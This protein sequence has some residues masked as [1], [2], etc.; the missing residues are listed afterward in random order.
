[1]KTWQDPRTRVT[2][3][4]PRSTVGIVNS[5]GALFFL[6]P[7]AMRTGVTD[8]EPTEQRRVSKKGETTRCCYSEAG[9]RWR[10]GVC[11][12]FMPSFLNKWVISA[13]FV[14]MNFD[15]IDCCFFMR[16]LE[17]YSKWLAKKWRAWARIHH[18]DK[19]PFFS[20]STDLLF[21]PW[22]EIYICVCV[23]ISVFPLLLL[24]LLVI[25]LLNN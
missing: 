20:L 1:M 19:K 17:D 10:D 12:L 23:F 16:N 14:L 5:S 4:R 11:I 6:Y 24:L 7:I 18:V 22:P 8:T 9:R 13:A 15:M 2:F 25:W 21:C 3:L